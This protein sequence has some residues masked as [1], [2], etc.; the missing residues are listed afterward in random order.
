MS[1]F[2]VTFIGLFAIV[3]ML[4]PLLRQL[5][6]EGNDLRDC[7]RAAQSDLVETLKQSEY[8]RLA[9]DHARDGLLV[10]DMSGKI[11]WS[12]RSFQKMHGYSED[13]IIG[14]NPL[15]FVMPDENTPTPEE[16]ANF[17]YTRE[18][19]ETQALQLFKNQRRDGTE[20]W[21]QLNVSYN[22]APDGQEHAIVS[23]RDVTTD[24]VKSNTLREAQ[25]RLQREATHDG[26]TGIPNRSAFLKFID[27]ALIRAHSVTVG[28][29]HI[30]LDRFKEINDTHG[31]S[32]G[33]AVLVHA[34]QALLSTAREKDLVARVGGDEFVVVC[35]D[36]DG[37]GA[38]HALATRLMDAVCEP[39]EWSNVILQSEVSIGGALAKSHLTQSKD[40]LI[41]S[42]FALYEAKRLGRNCVV[43]YD[44]DL[45]KRHHLQMRRASALMEAIDTDGLDYVFQPK[46]SLFSGEITGFETLVR[47]NDP[48]E[49]TI[50]PNDFLPL[51]DD[52]NLMGALDLLSMK[53][54]IAQKRELIRLGYPDMVVAFNASPELL[55]H[56]EFINR[57]VWMV[58][59]AG[60]NR[61]HIAIEVL[62]TTNFGVSTIQSSSAAIL[63]DLRTAGFLVHLDDFGIG[64][65]G[66]A[67]LAQL[68]I[69]GVKIDQGLVSNMLFDPT[70]LKIVRKLV[71]LCND[72]DL[73]VIA[74]GVEDEET[75]EALHQM[76]CGIVQ[77]YWLAKPL[78]PEDLP[79]W[80]A[81]HHKNPMRA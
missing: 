76:G 36:I 66:L 1:Y 35:P 57:L 80:L 32:A 55:N 41:E 71:E 3:L 18:E 19:L 64:F 69:T 7:L 37:F 81:H 53:A 34:A 20:F 59:A 47:W 28:L 74:E 22:K 46:M 29:L 50:P 17:R 15:E 67:H 45:E 42:D 31:H 30:D 68:D 12:N 44:Q 61:A 27:G 13:E 21:N 49:G 39:F 43:L 70:S 38:L 72:L 9:C 23:C 14:R 11:I 60:I 56:P 6:R 10:Q 75:A 79:D 26:L 4:I 73:A 33:D 63:R 2:I 8:Y 78:P 25:K 54:A 52:L 62:E 48:N 58:E 5:I 51:V 24:V 16:I 77:G 40:L 65:A